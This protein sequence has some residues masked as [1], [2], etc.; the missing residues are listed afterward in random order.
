LV[1]GGIAGTTA[2]VAAV[3]SKAYRAL[4]KAQQK[5]VK[6]A[7]NKLYNVANDLLKMS[8]TMTKNEAKWNK[9]TPRF[10]VDE[11]VVGL[12]DRE[13]NKLSTVDAV[14][15]L[16]TK[17]KA[18][19]DAF[20]KLLSDSGEYVS[21]DKL[22]NSVINDIKTDLKAKGSDLDSAIKYVEKEIEAYKN[23]YADLG[24]LQ[25]NGDM[26]LRIDD[27]NK[28]K[29]GLWSKTTNFNPTRADKLS[30]DI[31]YR[32]GHI[33]KEM[34]EDTVDDANVARLNSRLGDYAS[35]INVLERANGKVLPGG[36]FGKQFARIAGTIVG[37]GQGPVGSLMGNLTG[38][39]LADIM[40]DP[41]VQTSGWLKLYNTLSKT[42]QGRSI[43]DEAV[44]IMIQRGEERALRKL[45]EAPQWT[46]GS[47]KPDNSKLFTQDEA[48]EYLRSLKKDD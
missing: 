31:D 30:S 14:A 22:K 29:S 19:N 27:F 3:G 11:G 1:G 6:V 2:G 47:P 35:A 20:N 33:A 10:L 23:N 28:I 24:L 46:P 25:D 41:K 26:L 5:L 44:Q 40:M 13:G 9:N 8:P 18:E 21:I 43:I 36:F 37:M 45:L 42:E 15:A 4:P 16:R 12:L 32:M 48:E 39:A 17:Y 7:E 34:I 38:A